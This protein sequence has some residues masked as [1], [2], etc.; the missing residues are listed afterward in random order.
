MTNTL[1]FRKAYGGMYD[2]GNDGILHMVNN[3]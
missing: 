3:E 2:D 1:R